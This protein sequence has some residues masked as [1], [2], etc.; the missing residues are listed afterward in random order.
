MSADSVNAKKL[1][2]NEE[3]KEGTEFIGI[4]ECIEWF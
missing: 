2:S 3:E 4:G 1:V